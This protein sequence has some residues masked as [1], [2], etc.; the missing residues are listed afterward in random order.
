MNRPDTRATRLALAL[1]EN[2]GRALMA[3]FKQTVASALCRPADSLQLVTLSETDD[4]WSTFGAARTHAVENCG[5][6]G[7]SC[8]EAADRQ[9]FATAV[10]RVAADFPPT[11][12]LL[13]REQSKYCGAVRVQSRELFEHLF[14]LLELDGEDLLACT[15]DG[16]AGIFAAWW[17]EPNS[18]T[19]PHTY[20]LQAWC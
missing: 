1:R 2:K 7:F 17:E 18:A 15:P 10:F 8:V 20:A 12:L 9:D 3:D 19:V 11:D 5:N 14:S 16:S 4:A 13:F 6:P